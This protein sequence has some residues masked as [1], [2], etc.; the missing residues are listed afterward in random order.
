M[1]AQHSNTPAGPAGHVPILPRPAMNGAR[2]SPRP[3]PPPPTTAPKKRGR[4]S[5]ADRAKDLRPQLPQHLAPRPSE[6][7]GDTSDRR[8]ILPAPNTSHEN[9]PYSPI[10]SHRNSAGSSSS[11]RSLLQSTDVGRSVSNVTRPYPARADQSMQRV[12]SDGALDHIHSAP[13][14]LKGSE[15]P[16]FDSEVENVSGSRSHQREL[17]TTLAPILQLEPRSNASVVTPPQAVRRETMR[18]SA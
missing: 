13:L 2:M 17:T 5:R 16:H 1:A 8:P 14:Y 4:P 15:L 11:S 12:L 9:T 7:G 18:N 6:S 3:S 10:H